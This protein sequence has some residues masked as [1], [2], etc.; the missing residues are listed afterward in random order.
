MIIVGSCLLP[1]INFSHFE[2]EKLHFNEGSAI[3]SMNLTYNQKTFYDEVYGVL[4]ENGYRSNIDTLLGFCFNEMTIVAMDAI[5]YT[6]DQQPE[7]FLLHNFDDLPCPKY[8]IFSEWDSIV[9]YNHLSQ[10]DWNFPEGYYYYKCISNP[11]PNSG[12]GMTQS[13]IYCRK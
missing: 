8:I 12:L 10:L 11:D 1:T 5:P 9:L 6:N 3:A 13:M 7:E 4:S 2:K